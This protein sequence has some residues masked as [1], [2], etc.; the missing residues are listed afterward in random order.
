[1]TQPVSADGSA[2]GD[3]TGNVTE[4]GWSNGLVSIVKKGTF[5]ISPDKSGNLTYGATSITIT[6]TSFGAPRS[7]TING[8][9]KLVVNVLTDLETYSG[10]ITSIVLNEGSNSKTFTL[11]VPYTAEVDAKLYAWME[12]GSN[13]FDISST[14]SSIMRGNDTLKGGDGN[15]TLIWREGN[16]T[17]DG[18]NDD[19]ILD[20]SDFGNGENLYSLTE[21]GNET[22]TVTGT[23]A[24]FKVTNE[25]TREVLTAKNIEKV[26]IGNE[27][28]SVDRFLAPNSKDV[29]AD[30]LLFTTHFE[31]YTGTTELYTLNEFAT[32]YE[33]SVPLSLLNTPFALEDWSQTANY[34]PDATTKQTL[35]YTSGSGSKFTL[36]T[37]LMSD[38]SSFTNIKSYNLQNSAGTIKFN[39]S[40]FKR[41]NH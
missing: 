30:K 23:A 18:G 3:A 37:Q 13:A 15:D 4:A 36:E 7:L 32:D 20:L 12:D 1:M 38:A 26:K 41:T 5:S 29:A 25:V 22:Y 28:V 10:T 16:D 24:N 14:L 27:E 2:S 40:K 39:A 31:N 6:D 8:T 21:R 34:N 19:D 9:G 11:S 17:L 33:I 35:S